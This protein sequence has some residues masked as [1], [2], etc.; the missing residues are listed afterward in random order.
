LQVAERRR[1]PPKDGFAIRGRGFQPQGRDVRTLVRG[2]DRRLPAR[3]R[4][5]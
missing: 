3:R 4:G 2:S 1:E 5:V